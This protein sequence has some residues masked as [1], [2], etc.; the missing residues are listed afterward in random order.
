MQVNKYLDPNIQKAFLPT[1]PGVSEHQSKLAAI[2]KTAKRFKRSL[3]VAWLDIANAY[4]SVN[5]AL[6]QFS[7]AHYHASPEFRR[8]LQSWYSGL[9]ASVTTDTWSTPPIP[10]NIG[11]YQGDPFSVVIFLTVMN[12]LS[13]SLSTR[14][15]LGFSLPSSTTPINHLMYADDVCVISNSPAGC[16]HLLN[17]VQ[18]WL[19]WS[20]LKAKVE[21]CCSMSVQESTGRRVNSGIPEAPDDGYRFLGMCVWLFRNNNRARATLMEDLKRMLEAVDKAPVTH[22]Q[23]LRLYKLGIC[24]RIAWP[25]QVE[26]FPLTWL[27]QSLQPVATRFVKKWAGLARSFSTAILFLPEKRGGLALPSLV[28]LHKK[29]KSSRMAQLFSFSDAGVHQAARLHLCEEKGNHRVKFKP[30]VMVDEIRSQNPTKGRKALAQTAQVLVAEEDANH[31]HEHLCRLSSQG[32][33]ARCWVWES[34]QLWV[35]AVQNLPPEPMKFALNAALDTLPT[36]SNLHRW[37]KKSYDT[38]PLCS[39]HQS[40]LHILNNCPIAMDLCCYSRRHDEVL[41]LIGDFVRSHLHPSFL[42]TIDLASM[43]YSFPQHITPTDMRPDIVWWSDE[44][45]E[46]GMLELTISYELLVAD[47][48]Q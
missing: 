43:G 28:S 46:L 15:D 37:G 23:K 16:Q 4:G 13:E 12:T 34:P 47:S 2:I 33:M 8:L 24:P 3:S 39:S 27:E 9:S 22:Q 40:L 45:R 10:L 38:C 25:L 32:G 5:H 6:I 20:C 19:E 41:L 18:R 17:L 26:E 36:N 7:M 44:R 48:H 31:Q 30:A 29:Q 35:R 21:K 42:F 14:R 1:V 11:V